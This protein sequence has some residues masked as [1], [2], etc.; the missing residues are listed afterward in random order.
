MSMDS[1]RQVGSTG[2]AAA[3]ERVRIEL[4]ERSYEVEVASGALIRAGSL[5]RARCRP[6]AA[7]AF[8]VVDGQVP[9]GIVDRARASL[10]AASFVVATETLRAA[11]TEKSL[12]TVE[13]L[14][15]AIAATRHERWDPVLA[16][17]G[18]L[19]GDVAGFVAGIYRRGVPFIQCPTTLLSMVDASVGGKTGVNLAVEGSVKKNLV[20]V[21]HQPVGVLADLDALDSLPPRELGAGFAECV[22]H[23]L[24]S[25][26]FGDAGLWDWMR[27]SSARLIARDAAALKELVV[28]NVRV[29]AAVVA[30]DEREERDEG[31]R[32][33]LNLGHTFGHAIEPIPH[34]SPDGDPGH[35]PLLH[36]EAVALGL[37]AASATAE[38]LPGGPRGLTGHVRALLQKLGLPIQVAGLPPDDRLLAAMA[39]D[40]KAMGGRMR[41]V[42]PRDGARAAVVPDPNP[43]AVRA[44]LAAI[45]KT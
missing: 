43:A 39:H 16:L 38:H 26:E 7:R 37:V 28:R 41:L 4:R 18:G 45:R 3:T 1:A 14:L 8:M 2:P 42:L 21:F 22:K 5:A 10:E 25:A 13:R 19:V 12:A 40:K 30:G 32:A 44:G 29:K 11:E 20:G 36:G 17:G 35:A 9:P 15:T 33:L 27:A 6:G 34:L 23:A 31:G 24:I